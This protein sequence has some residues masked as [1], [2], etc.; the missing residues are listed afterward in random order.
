[1]KSTNPTQ[2]NLLGYIL[3]VSATLVRRAQSNLLGYFAA[4]LL[5]VA[6]LG[7]RPD[8][9]VQDAIMADALADSSAHDF[10]TRL[11][12]DFGGRLT[13]APGNEG[14]LHRTIEEL[15]ALGVEARL[16]RFK[17]PGWVR[18]QDEVTMLA[19][20]HRQL[21]VAALSYVQPHEPFEAEVVDI[22]QGRAEDIAALDSPQGKIGLLAPHTSVPRGQYEAAALAAGM[23]GILWINRVDGGQLLARTGSFNGEPLKIPVYSVTQEE[24]NWMLR[25]LQ[26]G[27][28][29][30]LR[31]HTRS[32]CTEVDTANI[33]VTFPGRTA[34]TVVIG[35]HFDSW[36]LGQGATDNG[37]GVAQLY[38]VAKQLQA[39]APQNLR[40]VE[41]VWFNG[42]EQGLWGARVHAPTL[43]DRPVAAMVNLDMVGFPLSVNAL[44]FDA[45][46]PVLEQFDASLGARRLK[47]GVANVNWFGSD[48][49]PYQLEGIPSITFGAHIEPD[50]VRYYHDLADTIDKVDPRMIPESSAT[51]AAL[52]YFLANVEE[53][54]VRRYSPAEMKAIFTRAGLEPRMRGVGLWPF[55]S[56]A[57]NP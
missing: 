57:D 20:L 21:R 38:A 34:D 56:T 43:K 31:M 9:A 3:Q 11:C 1:M 52:T 51:I 42:E 10:L 2:S 17:M 55:D 33:V 6:P 35:G 15:K 19:P 25:L 36:D 7:A 14:A 49:A 27:Q 50:K 29:V 24:G 44:G 23:R 39:H 41:L 47:Q 4:G 30:R 46:V 26:R 5:L 53:L 45:L 18:G 28:T 8:Q 12:D 54:P 16:E 40:T 32:Y 37:L 22:G 48:H 13:G